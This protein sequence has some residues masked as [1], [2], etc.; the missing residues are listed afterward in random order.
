TGV[1]PGAIF[2]A[3]GK[4]VMTAD[5]SGGRP[6]RVIARML[7]ATFASFDDTSVRWDDSTRAGDGA[8]TDTGVTQRGTVAVIPASTK[9][10]ANDMTLGNRSSDFLASARV[11]AGRSMLGMGP[12]FG[13]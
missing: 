5:P 3:D 6:V 10:R 12:R 11:R 2:T 13:G 9:A 4:P 7:D 8:G 1:S